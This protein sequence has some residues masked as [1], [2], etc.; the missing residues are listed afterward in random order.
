M[1]KLVWN[2]LTILSLCGIAPLRGQTE[3]FTHT[4]ARLEAEHLILEVEVLPHVL[5]KARLL[6]ERASNDEMSQNEFEGARANILQ[7]AEARLGVVLNGRNLRADSAAVTFRFQ[8]QPNAPKQIFI[9]CWYAL[10]L[11]PEHLHVRNEMFQEL[12]ETHRNFGTMTCGKQVIDFEFPSRS[13]EARAAEFEVSTGGIK[14]LNANTNL[15]S[16]A[17]LWLGAGLGGLIL[18]GGL[19]YAR[20][21]AR[22]HARRQRRKQREAAGIHSTTVRTS[23]RHSYELEKVLS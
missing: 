2:F 14:W 4:N 8:E 18:F 12:D 17:I 6:H 1:K 3:F 9:T 23:R 11:R 5:Q 20:K 19:A 21:L 16:P 7:Y 13:Q 22:H 10:L 15:H